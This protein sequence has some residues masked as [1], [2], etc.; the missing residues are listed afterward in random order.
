[1]AKTVNL[2]P[3]TAYSI[4][5]KNGFVGTEEEWLE[6]L[7]GPPGES[8]EAGKVVFT[9]N[10]YSAYAIGNIKLDNGRGKYASAGDNL[11]DVLDAIFDKESYPTTTQPSVTLTFPQAK[12]YEVGT[13]V[14]PSYSAVLNPGSYTYGPDTGITATSWTVIDTNGNTSDKASG[15]FDP[16]TVSDG[17]NYKITA[18]ATYKAGSIPITNQGNEYASGQIA[19]GSKSA[20]S[21]AVSGYRN[22]F[23]GTLTDKNDLI[24]DIIRGLTKSGKA[25][26]NGSSFT[27]NIPVGAVRVVFAYPA[28]LRDVT[29]AKDVNGMSAEIA[30]SFVQSTVQVE[31]VDGYSPID[32]KVYVLD[33]AEP[34]GTANTYIVR[35]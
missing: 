7:K 3:V 32:Y 24:S 26:T 9:R 23:Y 28:T 2:G 29:S 16:L 35:I 10:M 11:A 12:A 31:G 17:M 33:Y 8:V 34:I 19:A 5:V 1:M 6:S 14:T 20:T 30:S 22:T 18:T 21:G 4:A 15:S 25:L 27:I 13:S